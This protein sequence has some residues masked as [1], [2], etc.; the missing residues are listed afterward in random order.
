VAGHK[1]WCGHQVGGTDGFIAETQVGASET[2]RLLAVVCEIGLHLLVGVVTDDLDGVFVGTHR[3]IGSQSVKLGFEGTLRTQWQFIFQGQRGERHIVNDAHSEV[4]FGQVHTQ[5][6]KDS[7]DL[8]RREVFGGQTVTSADNEGSVGLAVE[9]VFH[10]QVE[11]F[12]GGTGLFGAVEHTDALG[13]FGHGCQ[14]MLGR[15]RP[16]QVNG[17]HTHLLA[18]GVE[19]VDAFAQG[20]SS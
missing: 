10:V 16:V 1:V 11:G 13:R 6:F 4:I 14:E 17:H 5:V 3:T 8:S 12:A 9:T 19:V 2:A 7:Q 20:L 18:V 15:E